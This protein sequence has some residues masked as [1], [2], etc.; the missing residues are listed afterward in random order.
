MSIGQGLGEL[1]RVTQE[2]IEKFALQLQN[3]SLPDSSRDR[4]A[5]RLLQLETLL[6]RNIE[7]YYEK[8][9]RI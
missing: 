1:N 6:E 7:D 2:E 3:S 4:A 5:T 9:R 8:V